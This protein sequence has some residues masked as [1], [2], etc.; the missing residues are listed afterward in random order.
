MPTTVDVFV[1]L[2]ELAQKS[3]PP[4]AKAPVP[5]PIGAPPQQEASSPIANLPAVIA[6]Y[7]WKKIALC[8][9]IGIGLAG[10]ILTWLILARDPIMRAIPGT[11]DFYEV[12]GLYAQRSGH[13]LAF[14]QV[15]SEL[16]YDGGTM[17]L[18]VD[19]IIHNS[20]DEAQLVPDIKAHAIG[21]DQLTIQSWWI[22]APAATVDAGSDIPFHTEVSTPMKHTI[23]NVT[24]EFD[25]QGDKDN[26]N[27]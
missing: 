24:L 8:I 27:Q 26:V 1:P 6:K 25:S 2:P 9:G 14:G 21:P 12:F 13:G 3:M 19:G 20:T 7:N 18:Y 10:L 23:E 22:P 17:R 11:R 15:K 5:P 16:R 4:T